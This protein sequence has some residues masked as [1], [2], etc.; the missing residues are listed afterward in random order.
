MRPY[1]NPLAEAIRVGLSKCVVIDG[2]PVG[3][4]KEEDMGHITHMVRLEVERYLGTLPTG[5]EIKRDHQYAVHGDGYI[6]EKRNHDDAINI[7]SKAPKSRVL[8]ER[9]V[10]TTTT[11]WR[12][13]ESGR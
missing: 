2:S 8:H 9:M 10:V 6:Y 1:L 3:L 7:V 11:R 5:G 12:S 13:V 4:I